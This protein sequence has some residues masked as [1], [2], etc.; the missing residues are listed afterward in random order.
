M[1]SLFHFDRTKPSESS[2]PVG[3]VQICVLQKFWAAGFI[4]INLRWVS[5][6]TGPT[7]Q[8]EGRMT[9]SWRSSNSA[10]ADLKSWCVFFFLFV[11]NYSLCHT[12]Q[13]LAEFHS[14]RRRTNP[15][16][17]HSLVTLRTTCTIRTLYRNL[18]RYLMD[19]K[20]EGV[21]HK[22]VKPVCLS[23]GP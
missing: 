18:M 10:T 13:W 14:Q 20:D 5:A 6:R 17:G 16:L 21:V 4:F 7:C 12:K 3:N 1:S 2:D 23:A 11:F 8:A 9:W 22:S 15:H 19:V